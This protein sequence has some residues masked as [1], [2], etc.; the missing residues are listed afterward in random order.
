M[1]TQERLKEVLDYNPETGIFT[2][3]VSRVSNKSGTPAGCL[4]HKYL[5]VRIDNKLY[6]CHRLAWLYMTG[7]FPAL[8]IDHIDNIQSNNKWLNLRECSNAENL[9]N[10]KLPSHNTSGAKGVRWSKACNKWVARCRVNYKDIHIG[11]FAN[12]DDAIKARNDYASIHHG[13]FYRES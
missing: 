10:T 7:K 6:Y 9:R 5:R 11:L 13:V 4:D 1:L 8:F 12:K 2:Y 3:K